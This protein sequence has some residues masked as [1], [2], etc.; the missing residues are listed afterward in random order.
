MALKNSQ[1]YIILGS[2]LL[3]L[4]VEKLF[5]D[6]KKAKPDAPS[7]EGNDADHEVTKW[8]LIAQSFSEADVKQAT[9]GFKVS[10]YWQDIMDG[11]KNYSKVRMTLP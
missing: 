11:P 4:F 9:R 7:Q 2:K 8:V 10:Q 6:A 3:P 1:G 5:A